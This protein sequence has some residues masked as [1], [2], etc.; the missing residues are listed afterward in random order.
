MTRLP[1]LPCMKLATL[2][3]VREHTEGSLVELWLNRSGRVVIRAFNECD[4]NHT[5]VDLIDLLHWA[6]GPG[7]GLVEDV[8]KQIAPVPASR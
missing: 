1:E 7:F 3:G 4:N 5:D 6:Q 8:T 2:N